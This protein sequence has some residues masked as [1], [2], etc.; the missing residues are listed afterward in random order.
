VN[1]ERIKALLA[2][3]GRIALYTYLALFALSM[4]VFSV[5]LTLGFD[6]KSAGAGIGVLGGA[7]LASK[8]IQP[9]R[10]GATLVLTPIVARVVQKLV[11]KP[12]AP[13]PAAEQASDSN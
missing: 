3:Y 6:V 13:E 10:I 7:W 1:K 8:A 4:T 11:R 9:L 5:L 12:T 2:E